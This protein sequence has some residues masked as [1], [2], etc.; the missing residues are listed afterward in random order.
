MKYGETYVIMILKG[1]VFMPNWKISGFADEI[2][3]DTDIQFSTL[4]KLGISHVEL[5][6]I[7][8]KNISK[9]SEEELAQADEKLRQIMIK[10]RSNHTGYLQNKKKGKKA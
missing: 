2:S 5:R 4:N 10:M 6:G 9:L 1:G 7:D 3:E 8:G